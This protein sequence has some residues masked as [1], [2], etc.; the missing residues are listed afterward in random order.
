MITF[1]SVAC[2][3]LIP[4]Q[5]SYSVKLMSCKNSTNA[6]P[7]CSFSLYFPPNILFILYFCHPLFQPNLSC[8]TS[9]T[10]SLISLALIVLCASLSRTV[11]SLSPLGC[12][13]H[14]HE[15]HAALPVCFF[16][17]T[18]VILIRYC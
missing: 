2:T 13:T 6:P 10:I 3:W 8:L 17:N 15:L 16:F 12:C 14:L 9:S 5:S 11:P 18:W 7:Q 4:Q 1:Q